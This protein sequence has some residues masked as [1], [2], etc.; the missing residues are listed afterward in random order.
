MAWAFHIFK[1]VFF[2]RVTRQLGYVRARLDAQ[3]HV[4]KVLAR[5]DSSG[6]AGFNEAE[7][8]CCRPAATVVAHEEPVLAPHSNAARREIPYPWWNPL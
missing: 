1:E 8:S 5:I 4:A 3:E 2:P 7:H 6:L